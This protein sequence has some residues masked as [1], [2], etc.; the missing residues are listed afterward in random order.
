MKYKAIKVNTNFTY[1]NICIVLNGKL[2][3]FQANFID[4]NSANCKLF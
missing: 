4:S 3:A 1:K 2:V